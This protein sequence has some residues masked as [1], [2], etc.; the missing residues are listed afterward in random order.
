MIQEQ[1]A[2]LLIYTGGTIGMLNK[3]GTDT[4]IPVDFKEIET[5]LPELRRF[6]FKI[7]CHTF[8]PA[9]DSSDANPEFWGELAEII[10]LNYE[11]YYGF[12]ILHGT[13]TMAYSASALSFMLENLSKP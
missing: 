11:N 13:D 6:N 8:K 4:L 12:V 9:I 10:K 1:N 3:P 2:I 5:Q 7:D